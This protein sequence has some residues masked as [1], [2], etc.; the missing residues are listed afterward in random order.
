M[1]P[2][3]ICMNNDVDFADC[4]GTALKIVT[5]AHLSMNQ[6]RNYL[7]R[8]HGGY[9]FGSVCLSVYL[10]VV[11]EVGHGPGTNEFNFRD[12]PE[13]I[14]TC[15]HSLFSGVALI[16]HW[17]RSRMGGKGLSKKIM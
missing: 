3:R 16:Q 11:G 13:V 17:R 15:V 5:V 8:K 9:V 2:G 4:T 12:D 7:R 10:S 1:R 14:L 6:S